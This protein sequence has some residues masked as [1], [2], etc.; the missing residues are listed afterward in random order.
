MTTVDVRVVRFAWTKRV[1]VPIGVLMMAI[2]IVGFWP[3]YFSHLL[4]GTLDKVPIIHVHAAVF[5]GW[6]I[7]VIAQAT[8]AGRGRIPLH[9]KVGRIGMAYG[10]VLIVVGVLTAISQFA[11]RVK[12]GNF[13][14]AEARLLA[15]LT[16]MLVFAPVLFAA[17]IYRRKPEIHKRLIVVATTILLVAAVHRTALF[18]G[19]PPPLGI[20]LAIWLAPIAVGMLHDVLT[21]RVIHPVYVVG[22]GLVLLLKS[23][24]PLRETGAWKSFAAWLATFFNA[25]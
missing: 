7:L 3:T 12:T 6:L 16:D 25:S 10:V 21:H 18:G 20:L 24:A 15:P 11:S 2:A 13:Q 9:R 23:R 5:T 8:L 4:K 17:W 14:Q 1:Y 22:I 19:P